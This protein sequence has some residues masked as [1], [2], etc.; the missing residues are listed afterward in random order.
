MHCPVCSS[1]NKIYGTG[2]VLNKYTISYFRCPNCGFINTEEP[3]WLDEAYNKEVPDNQEGRAKRNIPIA[4]SLIKQK[5]NPNGRYLDYGCAKNAFFVK[6]MRDKGF[7]CIGYDK[8]EKVIDE[9]YGKLSGQFEMITSWEVFEH[10]PNPKEVINELLSYT[11]TIVIGTQR[12]KLDDPPKLTWPYF[13]RLSGRHISFYTIESFCI[14]S[15]EFNLKIQ[16]NDTGGYDRVIL[17]K[18]KN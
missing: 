2:T 6:A 11:D 17:H 3:Y 12:I 1:E 13:S 18:E 15:K 4:T 14:I 8:Y 5:L 10:I 7:N 9:Y 16:T